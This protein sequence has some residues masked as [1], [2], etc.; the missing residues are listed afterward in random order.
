MPSSVW[1]AIIIKIS[2][3]VASGTRRK[4][5]YTIAG[6]L[7]YFLFIFYKK[8]TFF[9]ITYSLQPISMPVL[10]KKPTP[11]VI[12]TWQKMPKISFF[13]IEKCKKYRKCP[14][15]FY[16]IIYNMHEAMPTPCRQLM[17]ADSKFPHIISHY[18]TS[19]HIISH[20]ISHH[21]TSSHTISHDPTSSHIISH[22]LSDLT[23][24]H[25]IPHH[26]TSSHIIS[27][28]LT[29][30]HIISHH[31]DIGNYYLFFQRRAKGPSLSPPTTMLS[32]G[33]N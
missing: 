1:K 19:S 20:T 24:S 23:S 18:L 2:D 21:L 17:S 31:V 25:I 33:P 7:W 11:P 26:L 5:F 3:F 29:S 13:I 22:H 9:F 16:T 12:I 4:L 6:H 30:S 28:H 32:F 10:F 27:H 8:Y 14:A 15:L